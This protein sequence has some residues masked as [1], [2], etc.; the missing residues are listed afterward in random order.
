MSE[1]TLEFMQKN[2]LATLGYIGQLEDELQALRDENELM[3][4]KARQS[5]NSFWNGGW[6][7]IVEQSNE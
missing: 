3:K 7:I 2:P 5:F 6:Y 4:R 1:I